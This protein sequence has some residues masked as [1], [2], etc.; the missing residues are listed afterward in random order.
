MIIRCC[1]SALEISAV[2]TEEVLY[3][4]I[5]EGC[6]NPSPS[7]T[8]VQLPMQAAYSP[9]PAKPILP[10]RKSVMIARVSN[11]TV[12]PHYEPANR[13]GVREEELFSVAS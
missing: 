6:R 7:P 5:D 9:R 13:S 12:E 4:A 3:F 8:T 1:F 2:A 10:W 11:A